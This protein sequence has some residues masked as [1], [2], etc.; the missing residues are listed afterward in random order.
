MYAPSRV[1]RD[2]VLRATRFICAYVYIRMW[3]Y[4]HQINNSVTKTVKVMLI[5]FAQGHPYEENM[6]QLQNYSSRLGFSSH[7]LWND[8]DVFHDP[9][10]IANQKRFDLLNGC[11]LQQYAEHNCRPFCA[12]VKPMALW[13]GLWSSPS[14]YVMWSD[15]KKFELDSNVRDPWT[16]KVTTWEVPVSYIN[17]QKA[18]RRLQMES[19]SEASA[20]GYALDIGSELR[21][22]GNAFV[23]RGS[24]F[25]WEALQGYKDYV[26]NVSEFFKRPHVINP[27]MLIAR[28]PFN[29]DLMWQWFEM[30]MERPRAFC[31]SSAQ[32][33]AA[34]N[35]LLYNRSIPLLTLCKYSKVNPSDRMRMMD[36]AR[37]AHSL[38]MFL[39]SL[40]EGAFQLSNPKWQDL[41][42][43]GCSAV[44]DS[45]QYLV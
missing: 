20:F 43:L 5:S 11:L 8:H 38:K 1:Q 26:K 21:N 44:L 4:A 36:A 12:A 10:Y 45:Y 23:A 30:A 42:T 40:A 9:V 37:S 28:T 16:G 41:T 18:V 27:N 17:V 34:L 6:L 3:T 13:R 39:S 15:A 33:Q 31:S 7:M 29:R 2:I 14:D 22:A 25:P 19:G 35:I 24:L 32:D